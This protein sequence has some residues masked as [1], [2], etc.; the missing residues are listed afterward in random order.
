VLAN[1]TDE[2]RFKVAS[3]PLVQRIGS[4][5]DNVSVHASNTWKK[6]MEDS[7]KL[8]LL[9]ASATPKITLPSREPLAKEVE[10]HLFLDLGSI[11]T[12]FLR[13]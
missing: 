7:E 12:G 6:A 9:R 11:H 1:K 2:L 4:L 5:I 3:F 8:Q 10:L 13:E